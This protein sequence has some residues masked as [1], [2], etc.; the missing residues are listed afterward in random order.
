[1]ACS[2]TL[3]GVALDCGNVG[4]LKKVYIAPIEDVQAIGLTGITGGTAIGT[5][6][7]VSGKKFKEFSFRK[8]N[9]NFVSTGTRDDAAG[10]VFNST[11][12]TLQFNKMETVKRTEVDQLSKGN[13]YVIAQDQ[14]GVNWFIGYGSY[15]AG[16]VNGQSGAQMGE[17]NNYV[18]TLTSETADLPYEVSGALLTAVI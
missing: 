15:A 1:M 13:T 3:T 12:V 6:T 4:G 7:M 9:A 18:V 11:V 16:S 2:I 14:N 10:T 5:L 17:S 8:G